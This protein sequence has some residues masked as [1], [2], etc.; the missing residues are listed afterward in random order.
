M[1]SDEIRG[2]KE[3]IDGRKKEMKSSYGRKSIKRPSRMGEESGH[4]VKAGGSVAIMDGRRA[5][6]AASS[7]DSMPGEENMALSK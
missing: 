6:M 1:N 5:R 4:Q 7:R 3:I 2:V